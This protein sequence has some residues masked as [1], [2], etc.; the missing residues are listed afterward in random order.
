MKEL[1]NGFLGKIYYATINNQTKT[2]S[3]KVDLTDS[4]IAC[5]FEWFR[6]NMRN[7]EGDELSEYSITY[8]S[9]E[10]ELVMRKKERY[11]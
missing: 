7:E 9:S 2:M 11:R 4:A 5:V 1:V 10:Y 6:T 3:N 8:P